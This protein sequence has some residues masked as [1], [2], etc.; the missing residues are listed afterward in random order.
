MPLPPAE[1]DSV[2]AVIVVKTRV[3]SLGSVEV[4]V[5]GV[6]LLTDFEDQMPLQEGMEVLRVLGAWFGEHL[7]VDELVD[8]T[9]LHG[10]LCGSVWSCSLF[11]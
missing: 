11:V 6:D 7:L 8:W 2:S 4:A 1:A 10:G 9:T 5:E 3:F